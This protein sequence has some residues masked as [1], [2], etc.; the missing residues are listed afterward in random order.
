MTLNRICRLNTGFLLATIVGTPLFAQNNVTALSTESDWYTNGASAVEAASRRAY[1]NTP[2]AAKNIILFV[3]DGM[4]VS[5]VTAARIFAGQQQGM[6]GEEYELSYEK[7]PWTGLS[8][9]YTTDTQVSDSAGTATAFMSGVKTRSG[10]INIDGRPLRGDCA[11]YMATPDATLLTALELAEVA[12]KATG[13]VSTARLT[14]ATPAAAYANS[15]DRNWEAD[16]DMPAEAIESGCSDI[17]KQL[18]EFEDRLKNKVNAPRNFSNIDGIEVAF[19]GGR[20]NFFGPDPDSIE[21]FAEAPG[22]GR[23]ADGRNLVQEWKSMGGIYVMDQSGF[24][25]LDTND[26]ANVLGLFQPAHMRYEANRS[27]DVA[28]EPSLTEMT[29]RAIN[30]LQ[31]DPDGFFL[32]VEGGRVD[33]AH[34]A[35]SAYNALNEAVELAEAVQAAVDM[36]D[37]NETLIIVTAD[38]SHVMTLAGYPKRGNPILGIAGNDVNGLPYT[39]LSY[40]NGAGFNVSGSTDADVRS[41]PP[42]PGRHDLTEVDTNDPGYHQETL[43]ATGGETHAGEDVA[44]YAIGPGAHLLSGSI[45]QNVIF[46]VMNFAGDLVKNA[47]EMLE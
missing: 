34:H 7:F 3:G 38:H 39:T 46:H 2:G 24:D 10:V 9:T 6:N 1:N 47:S 32:Q 35:N 27:E 5:T 4:G 11:G 43:V 36:V 21:G 30:I 28:G 42:A 8:K 15:P 33:H 12:G 13:I 31:K 40:A 23:R 19:G 14:H 37:T 26:D 25:S 20:R 17:A 44:I 41:G 22:E 45:E 16:S 29:V 18:I